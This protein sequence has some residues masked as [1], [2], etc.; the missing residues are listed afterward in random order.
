MTSG[1]ARVALAVA[2]WLLPGAARAC[3]VCFGPEEDGLSAGLNAGIAVLLLLV[4]V[5]QVLIVRF[6]VRAIRRGRRRGSSSEVLP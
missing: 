4:L 2:L 3:S 6:F 5:V 1:T